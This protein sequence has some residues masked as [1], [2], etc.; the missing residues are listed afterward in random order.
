MKVAL[1]IGLVLLLT[2]WI[3]QAVNYGRLTASLMAMLRDI[4]HGFGY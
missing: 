2:Y 4:E 3:D 1:A